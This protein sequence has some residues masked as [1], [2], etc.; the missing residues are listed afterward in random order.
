MNFIVFEI[1]RFGSDGCIGRSV[2]DTIKS[3]FR[4]PHPNWTLTP[5]HV[6]PTWFKYF[7]Q[8]WNWSIGINEQVKQKFN[9]KAKKRL[10]NIVSDWK[11]IYE[12]RGYEARPPGLTK[13]VWDGLI[14][15]WHDP[16][17]IRIASQ[18]SSSRM[19]RDEH[20][21]LPMVHTTG[22]TPHAVVRLKMVNS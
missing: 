1:F 9:E 16:H 15:Y 3:Y 21:N 12:Q 2:S 22:Q 20:G 4:E 10:C 18:C 13:D 7:A 8:K 19:T 17:S 5:R 6:R 11:I 14:R